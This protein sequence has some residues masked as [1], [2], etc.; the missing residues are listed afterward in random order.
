MPNCAIKVMYERTQ[1]FN[2]PKKAKPDLKNP[3]AHIVRPMG[4]IF[5]PVLSCVIFHHASVLFRPA[6]SP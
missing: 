5:R 6:L 3:W 4:V 1:H 2:L